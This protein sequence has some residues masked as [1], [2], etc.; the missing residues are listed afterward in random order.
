MTVLGIDPGLAA[1][2]WGVVSSTG[3][4]H[5]HVAHGVV[6]TAAGVP[7]ELRL[8]DI[9][10]QICVLLDEHKPD[11]AAD[12]LAAAVCHIHQGGLRVEQHFR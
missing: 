5:A 1:L 11:H 2:G 12:A 6:K 4:R 9:Y 3:N 10:Q 8:L 7:Q